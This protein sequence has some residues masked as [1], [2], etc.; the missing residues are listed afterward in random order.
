[1]SPTW[2][3][4]IVGGGSAGCVLANR[5]SADSRRRVLLI[6]AGPDLPP[7][8]E[9]EA[10]RDIY[11][12]RA[13]Y[14]P[15]H[16]WPD[17]MAYRQPVGGNTAERPPLAKYE[18]A[19]ILGGGSSINGQMANR[20][21]PADYD[22]WEAAGALGWNWRSVLPYFR[23]LE[24]DLDYDGPLHGKD[25]PILIHRVPAATW[26]GFALGAKA[27]I[28][29]LG[30]ANLGD[31]NGVYTDGC[32]S[33]SLSNDGRDR[34]ST[35]RGYLSADIR[36]R[37]N[38]EVMTETIVRALIVEGRTV[39]GVE[40]ERGAERRR[41]LARRTVL[42]AGAVHSPAFLLRAG[43]GRAGAL[44]DLGIQVVADLPGVGENLQEHPGISTSAF[45]KRGARL[46]AGTRRHMLFGLRYSSGHADC[47]ASDM[48]LAVVARSAWHPLGRRIGTLITWLN[49]VHSRGWVRL[50]SADPTAAPLV[51]LNF[52]ADQRDTDRLVEGVRLMAT[53]L[54]RPELAPMIDCAAPSAYIDFAKALG[55][56]TPRNYLMTAPAACLLDVVPSLREPF[57]RRFLSNGLSLTEI[58]ADDEALRAFVQTNAIA[59]WHVSGTCRMGTADMND[60]VVDPHSMAVH[61][62][63]G[64]HVADA[65]VMPT[66]PRANTNIPTIMV[67]ERA[68]DLI[69]ETEARDRLNS[70]GGSLQ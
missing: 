12:A 67:A 66:V 17:L 58:I 46:G 20:G 44:R 48:Y 9:P 6:E 14:D 51:A 16:H 63:A 65:S 22:D 68:A 60:A 18:Q 5:L 36:A 33:M 37:P 7:G 47:P 41:I 35:A 28:E 29:A 42:A 52:L 69:I 40:V 15:D 30:H 53:I 1:M 4:V 32:F 26:P 3:V 39:V 64:L 11:P 50:A 13:A 54:A 49:K 56:V 43:I 19:R 59:Q 25:G 31:Q 62:V 38:L 8:Q 27:A 2:D 70:T 57:F 61:G 10:I 23:R 45:I 34:V 55:K 21:T 24:T